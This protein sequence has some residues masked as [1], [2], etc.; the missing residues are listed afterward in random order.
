MLVNHITYHTITMITYDINNVPAVVEEL[1]AQDLTPDVL[2]V[3][4]PP[5]S[6]W[7]DAQGNAGAHGGRY[8]GGRSVCSRLAPV[9]RA[10]TPDQ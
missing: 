5:G 2:R 6:H 9:A 8:L 3:A 7:T 4:G 10:C 1:Y